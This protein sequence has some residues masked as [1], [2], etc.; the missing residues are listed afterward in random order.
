MTLTAALTAEGDVETVVS[1]SGAGARWVAD[2][3]GM[4]ERA[5]AELFGVVAASSVVV[6]R[7]EGT[8]GAP[9]A[10]NTLRVVFRSAGPPKPVEMPRFGGG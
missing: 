5:L 9:E 4:D 3:A 7:G 2:R 8:A 10:Q 6:E 1:A